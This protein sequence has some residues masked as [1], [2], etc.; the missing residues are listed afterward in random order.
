MASPRA[1]GFTLTEVLIACAVAALLAAVALPSF[2]GQLLK[3]HR[4]DAVGSLMRLQMAQEKLR[5]NSGLY[6]DDLARLRHP[7]M[8][9]MT[10]SLRVLDVSIG[11]C[12]LFLPHDVPSLPPGT[13]LA[14]VQI[15]LDADTRFPAQLTLQHV[16]SILPD[17][18]GVRMGC[19]WA[20]LGGSAERAL[21]R[22]IDHTQKQRRLMVRE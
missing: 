18:R 17:E 15:E 2:R 12:P 1:R 8:P 13:R 11:G 16:S 19:E 7:A 22:Y 9:E 6:S 20:P 5:S 10:V 4:T 14:E 21:Q 3:A